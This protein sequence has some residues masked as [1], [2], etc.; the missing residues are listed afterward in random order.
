MILLVL[1]V[2]QNNI[3]KRV[4]TARKLAS[5][6]FL[7]RRQAGGARFP[8]AGNGVPP[9]DRHQQIGTVHIRPLA[10]LL[11]HFIFLF[12][13]MY[14]LVLFLLS[15]TSFVLVVFPPLFH[16]YL[17]LAYPPFSLAYP[18]SPLCYL[19]PFL[20]S[21]FVTFSFILLFLS[22]N[23]H[24]LIFFFSFSFF[25]LKFN[26]SRWSSLVDGK[27]TNKTREVSIHTPFK[28]MRKK[29]KKKPPPSHSATR[30]C[31][32]FPLSQRLG[33]H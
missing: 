19:F 25:F 4:P 32:P 31:P 13:F 22:F 6:I 1:F 29:K 8:A 14:I 10:D 17:S 16:H 24:H 11:I 26:Q 30:A 15:S 9:P 21:L 33:I 7:W 2:R 20:L 28:N 3:N 23:H 5:P 12:L 18:P 27:N